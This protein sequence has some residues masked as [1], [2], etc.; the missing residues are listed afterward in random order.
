MKRLNPSTNEI[1]KRGDSRED[2]YR[3]WSY[4]NRLKTNGFFVEQWYS[5]ETY[6]KGKKLNLRSAID[7]VER[8]KEKF[9][10]RYRKWD[11]TN[12]HKK[13]ART[14]K[15]RSVKMRRTPSWLTDKQYAEMATF[16]KVAKQQA[17]IT[18]IPHHVDHIVPLQ[19][20]NVSGLHVP[21]NL[22]VITAAENMSKGN[23]HVI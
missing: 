9:K 2:G 23:F 10:A 12:Q 17:K 13:N 11:R 4:T 14:A 18:G 20:E 16:Y 21:W 15:Y 19:G 7:W 22:Q 6:E 1:F 8:N 5:P 3:F